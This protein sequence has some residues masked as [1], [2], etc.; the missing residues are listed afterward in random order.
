MSGRSGSTFPTR[1]APMRSASRTAPISRCPDFLNSA[2]TIDN[3]GDA[4]AYLS[5][6]RNSR[7]CS[8]TRPPSSAARRRAAILAPGWSIDLALEQ[9][10]ELRAPAAE[11]STMVEFRRQPRGRQEYRRRLAG[12]GPR[13]S[14]PTRSIRRSTGE[15]A[16]VTALRANTPAGRRRVARAAGRRDLCRRAGRGDDHQIH[17]RRRSTRSGLQQVAE[18]SAELDKILR[19]AGL[20][21]GTVGERL[22]ALN[23][24]PGP[25][26]SRTPTRAAPQLIAGLN[27]GVKAMYAQ[28]PQAFATLPEPAARNPPRAAG[29]PGR[30]VERLLPPRD[31]RWLA[32]GDLLHQPEDRPATGRNIRCRR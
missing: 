1:K 19:S 5:R 22:A 29:N 9:M 2:H 25:A 23:K 21:Q 10:R 11:Q 32:P 31:A 18:I 7:P 3:A 14:S 6:L 8:T 30:R 28:L 26:L 12:A 13:R 4:E 20:H 17:R 15:I 16:A 27:A 24:R